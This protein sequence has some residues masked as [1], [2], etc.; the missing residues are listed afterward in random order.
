MTLGS[1]ARLVTK[2]A[3]SADK[4]FAALAEDIVAIEKRLDSRLDKS[5]AK[6]ENV[7]YGKDA[8]GVAHRRETDLQ[9]GTCLKGT[10]GR[11]QICKVVRVPSREVERWDWIWLSALI[12][13]RSF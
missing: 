3:S 11:H 12:R 13:K 4:K 9:T 10:A 6:I 5:D 8:G 2:S 1:L 7:E